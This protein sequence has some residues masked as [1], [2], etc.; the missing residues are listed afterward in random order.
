MI[1][2]S[3]RIKKQVEIGIC[4]DFESEVKELDIHSKSEGNLREVF[5][6]VRDMSSTNYSARNLIR[7]Y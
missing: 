5:E 2:W 4:R 7:V 3:E 1:L 6:L